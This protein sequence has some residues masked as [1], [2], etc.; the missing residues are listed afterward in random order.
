MQ[1]ANVVLPHGAGFDVARL[2]APQQAL[3][4]FLSRVAPATRTETVGLE[5]AAGRVLAADIRCDADYPAQPRS[6]MDGY[7]VRAAQTPGTFRIAGDVPMGAAFTRSLKADEAARIPTGGVVPE[8]ADAVVPIEDAAEGDGNVRVAAHVEAGDCINPA[9]GDMRAG[10]LVL[11]AGRW[12]GA[13]ESGVLATLGVTRVPVF[14]QPIIAILSNG[15]ELTPP[16]NVPHPGQVRDS[17]R[18]AIAASLRA[19]GARAVHAPTVADDAA[20]FGSALAAALETSDAVVLTGGSSVGERDLAARAIAAYSPGVVVHGLRVK[21]G[22]PTVLGAS[23]NV[24]IV[25]LPGNPTS[26][27]MI[28]EAVAAPIVAALVGAPALQ[29]TVEAETRSPIAGREGWTWYVPVKLH[30]EGERRFADA[31]PLRS[32]HVSLPARAAGY[33]VVDERGGIEAGARVR[34]NRFL[35]GGDR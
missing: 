15:D 4:A 11:K 23:G 24:P 5:V 12:I 21:P 3:V 34:V 8:G 33:V 32:S 13:P 27:L 9:A 26:S 16:E 17:N 19:M 25:G 18:F 7:A 31:L 6:S 28:L 35:S 20:A 30:D 29:E 10:E 2:L 14:A 22:K 1:G